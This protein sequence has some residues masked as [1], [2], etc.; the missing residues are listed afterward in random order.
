MCVIVMKP[1]GIDMPDKD[2][3][4]SCWITNPHGAG[5]SIV[6]KEHNTVW[7]KKGFMKFDDLMDY[8]NEA[9]KIYNLKNSAVMLHFRFVS[10]G[11]KCK[12]QCHP[13]PI[14]YKL[15]DIERIEYNSEMTFSH[16]G[17][18]FIKTDKG[19]S[20]TQIYAY[21]HLPY[22]TM[23][24]IEKDINGSFNRL[25]FLKNDGTYKLIGKFIKD[26]GCYYSNNSYSLY[27]SY[28][29]YI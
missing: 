4:Y 9:D 12:T 25:C 21:K 20:D 29:N 10:V 28:K 27:K 18:L 22:M 1:N 19:L 16:N 26:K 24:D 13:F 14:S 5:V 11:K 15:K 2:T 3:L 8:L 7:T 6:D 23:E 17:T